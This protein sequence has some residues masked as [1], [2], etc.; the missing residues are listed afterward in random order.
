MKPEMVI[1]QQQV[2][3][4]V[5]I[6]DEVWSM[7]A[8]DPDVDSEELLV[9]AFHDCLVEAGVTMEDGTEIVEDK[10]DSDTLPSDEERYDME[11]EEIDHNPF[12]DNEEASN[13]AVVI[14]PLSRNLQNEDV[15][16]TAGEG[17][18]QASDVAGATATLLSNWH[19]I[20]AQ[21]SAVD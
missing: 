10:Y 1:P 15:D 8:D 2:E 7:S 19:S 16:F 6:G 21:F 13:S 5:V 9:V 3:E 14:A 11:V 17:A 20:D 4:W 12:W 18:A